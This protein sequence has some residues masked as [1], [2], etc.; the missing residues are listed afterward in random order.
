MKKFWLIPL[1]LLLAIN[2]PAQ[3]PFA[4]KAFYDAFKNIFADGQKGFPL[5][6]GKWINEAVIFYNKYTV[7]L[8]LPGADSGRLSVPQSV[9]YPLATYFFNGGKTLAQARAKE[10][11]LHAALRTAWGSPLHEMKK[12]D[13]AKPVIYYRT[14]FYRDREAARLAFSEFDTY[15]VLYNGRYELALNINGRNAA[16]AGQPAVNTPKATPPKT[17]EPDLETKIRALLTS[18][19]QFFADEKGEQISK[20]EYYTEYYSRSLLFGKKSKLKERKYEISYSFNLDKESLP[21]PDDAKA[22][23]EKLI[24]IFT[25]TG[26]FRFNPETKEPSRSWTFGAEIVSG[27]KTSRYTVLVEY[28]NTPGLQSVGFLITRQKNF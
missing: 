10:A 20:S 8:Q 28:Y 9:G 18:M 1:L 12:N 15:L 6:K 17:T 21:S 25:S 13:T 16:D 27:F 3:N 4:N 2:S 24:S 23:Y 14:F 5:T 26:R 22:I 19:D 11:Q 7:N